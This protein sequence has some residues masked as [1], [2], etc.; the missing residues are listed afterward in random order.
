MPTAYRVE[1]RYTARGQ[2]DVSGFHVR[3]SESAPLS[4]VGMAALLDAV[5]T[6]LTTTFRAMLMTTD[7]LVE[8]AVKREPDP[9]NPS[10]LAEGISKTKN[11]A[12][13]SSIS[14]DLLPPECCLVLS[15]KTQTLSRSSRGHMFLPPA[16]ASTHVQGEQFSSSSATYTTAQAFR[17]ALDTIRGG[18]GFNITTPAFTAPLI[19]YSKTRRR[20]GEDPWVFDVTSTAVRNRV[21]WLRSRASSN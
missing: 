8:W 2:R 15:F 14:G 9:T 12:G 19:V 4:D 6:A 1:A 18:G 11:L 3:I 21:H 13:T 10:D 20:R 5:D 7:Q 16:F 17:D